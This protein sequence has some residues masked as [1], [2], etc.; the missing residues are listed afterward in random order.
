MG[1]NL[2]NAWI[3]YLQNIVGTGGS[4]VTWNSSEVY[5]T[6]YSKYNIASMDYKTIYVILNQDAGSTFT[7]DDGIYQKGRQM[8]FVGN[9]DVQSSVVT[10]TAVTFSEGLPSLDTNIEFLSYGTN[11]LFDST[12][13]TGD[14]Y[15]KNGCS[16]RNEGGSHIIKVANNPVILSL[17]DDS[18]IGN[19]SS[20]V[21]FDVDDTS[22]GTF[23][24]K[25]KFLD[26]AT[27]SSSALSCTIGARILFDVYSSSS[28]LEDI[29]FNLDLGTLTINRRYLSQKQIVTIN[30]K[31]DDYTIT[32]VD[33]DT[34]IEMNKSTSITLTVPDE[35]SDS[36][37]PIGSSISVIQKGDG[38]VEFA[39][40]GWVN[41]QYSDTPAG[42][43]NPVTLDADNRGSVG[44]ITITGDGSNDVDALVLAWNTA[45]PTNTV[46][47]SAGG[48]EVPNNGIDMDLTG[49]VDGSLI[50]SKGGY[51]K[52][53]GKF[54][55]ATL[56]KSAANTWYLVGD[57][58][59]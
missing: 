57:L 26:G 28:Y 38:Q 19:G 16:L 7:I 2:S 48:S 54:S 23:D 41:A 53:S 52:L 6:F 24:L 32:Y 55:G 56:T 5:S 49:G 46:T 22:I 47:V 12:S 37:L 20:P 40:Y 11:P 14:F 4:V 18:T 8:V 17:Y 51:L 45:N 3:T 39:E 42:A 44:N 27:V 10:S 9:E 33:V 36:G 21:I 13:E 34:L 15:L 59:A 31:L 25:I 58:V 50:N 29:Y 1:F 35:A 43:S 30:E